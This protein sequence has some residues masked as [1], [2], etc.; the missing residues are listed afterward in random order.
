[1]MLKSRHSKVSSL[2][3]ATARVP[4]AFVRYLDPANFV[5]QTLYDRV[6]PWLCQQEQQR[7]EKL[8]QPALARAYLA[9]HALKRGL[10]AQVVGCSPKELRFTATDRGKP[11]ISAPSSDA[12]WHFNLSH[13]HAMV[14]VAASPD[15]I[16]IDIESLTRRVPD[17]AIAKR[18]FSAHEYEHI[19]ASTPNDQA[20]LFLRYW[21]LK[22]AF[23]KA[24]G[25]GL[26]QRLD[27]IAFS[28]D[29]DIRL[30]VLDPVAQPTKTWRFWQQ[31]VA[32]HL[33]AVARVATT[34]D[35]DTSINCRAWEPTD[36]Q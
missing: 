23:L 13:T 21:T 16:G 29:G 28:L 27:A 12:G 22:E 35:N 34:A 24:E 33:M 20:Q 1:M 25:W 30:T 14:A 17:M 2:K 5:N 6:L 31:P 18:Y 15:P 9:A 19:A 36:W 10:L 8:T 3:P 11:L 7:L 32:G 4:T 26:S